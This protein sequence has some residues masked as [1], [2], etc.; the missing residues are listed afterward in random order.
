M[1]HPLAI[2]P[3]L[4]VAFLACLGVISLPA[5]GEAAY[6]AVST[7]VSGSD[8]FIFGFGEVD[9]CLVPPGGCVPLTDTRI[10]TDPAGGVQMG[11]A[12]ADFGILLAGSSGSWGG[13][14]GLQAIG[15][16][17]AFWQ[18]QFVVGCGPLPCDVTASVLVTGTLATLAPLGGPGGFAGYGATISVGGSSLGVAADQLT[19]SGVTT[20]IGTLAPLVLTVTFTV[21]SG[22][23]VFASGLL[24]TNAGGIGAGASGSSD[25]T[26]TLRWLGFTDVRDANGDPVTG[27]TAFSPDTGIDWA[28][29]IPE[30]TTA[31]LLAFGLAAL[32]ATHARRRSSRRR[33]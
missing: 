28:Q 14:A 3:L 5:P 13:G 2:R 31:A 9:T 32:S 23:P 26:S 27:V 1:G 33:A 29:P 15:T 25:F 12:T 11:T 22:A 7:S 24:R 20:T 4:A 30:P 17:S 8:G 10:Q 21:N 18:D 16:S 6:L 19:Q